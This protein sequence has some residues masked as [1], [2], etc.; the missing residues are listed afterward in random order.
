MT[1]AWQQYVNDVRTWLNQIQSHSETDSALE[2]EAM[3]FK[4]ELRDLEENDEHYIQKRMED[5]YNNLHVREDRRC[6]AYGE[7]LGGTG[8]DADGVCTVE[9][10]RHFNT[11]ID[12]KRSRSAT[13]VGVTFESVDEKGQALNLAE[14]AIVQSEVGPFLRALARQGLTVSAL[15]NH[16]IN[17]DPFIMYV[18][19]QDVSEPV[20]FAE[21][22]HEAFK[23]L[24]RM[25]VQ[26]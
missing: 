8:R 4:A 2:K 7:T 21:K 18:H 16:W 1:D 26:K 25:P 22:L 12:G 3:N 24:N 10:K 19:I 13:P 5:I 11:T 14:V 6:K 20:K 9:L 15:H 23:S 17:I